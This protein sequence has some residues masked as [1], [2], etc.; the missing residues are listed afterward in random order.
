MNIDLISGRSPAERL[1]PVVFDSEAAPADRG[2]LAVLEQGV[3]DADLAASPVVLPDFHHKSNMEMP[4]SIVVAT[5]ETIRPSFSS[6]SLNCG[7]GLIALDMEPAPEH[8]VGRFFDNVKRR[9]P[10]PPRW[11]REL[12]AGDVLRAATDG[13]RFAAERFGVD[14]ADLDRVEEGGRLDL[15]PYGGARRARRE[16]P[17]MAREISR[18]R[19]GTVGPSNHF[20]ELQE[21]EEILEPE[22]ADL[23]GV[24]QGQV[25]LQYHNGGGPLTT[26]MG[27]LFGG[28]KAHS[29]PLRA[30]MLLQKPLHQLGSAGSLGELRQRLSLYFSKQA[31]PIPRWSP[32][33]E[34]VM[35]A[36]ALAMN[37][38][39]AFRTATYATLRALARE[40]F[41]EVSG[42]L[43]VDSPHNSIYEEEV[44]GEQSLVHRHNSCRAYPASRMA[45]HPVFG[46]TGQPL[47]LPGLHYTSSY[48]CVAGSSSVRSL[49]SACHGAGSMIEGFVRR[50]IS[51]P[52]ERGRTTSRFRYDEDQPTEVPHVDDRGVDQ[53]L[54]VLVSNGLARPVARL[55]PFAVLT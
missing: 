10:H 43:V 30:Q 2:A 41:G 44:A 24:R 23:L 48:L 36:N 45:G 28:R 29:K 53:A 31:R 26:L 18:L 38:G 19:F 52:D 1:D 4:S 27:A 7:M 50:G 37:Y 21:V 35:L 22:T 25:T 46:V 55:R 33:G 16:L 42:R 20:V 3:R 51:R 5:R 17:W 47:L 49:H 6:A 9:Y 11:R 39:F 54:A 32:E 15:E 13:A 12:S 34:R 8:A 14:P 40:T